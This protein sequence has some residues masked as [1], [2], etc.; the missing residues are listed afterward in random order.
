VNRTQPAKAV[1]VSRRRTI[2]EA[3]EHA[4]VSPHWLSRVLNGYEPVSERLAAS[5][6]S[7]LGEPVD[8]LFDFD[9]GRR[10]R[11]EN[12]ATDAH[13]LVARTTTA[14]GLPEQVT[15]PATL[16]RVAALVGTQPARVDDDAA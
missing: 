11:R 13:D 15:D 16:N 8:L 1:L 14:Q 7:F 2:T 4:E 10:G 3:A 5:V 6:A 9:L 12:D